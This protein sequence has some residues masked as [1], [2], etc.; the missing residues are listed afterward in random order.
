MVNGSCSQ[1]SGKRPGI[2][3]GPEEEFPLQIDH[4]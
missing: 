2:A 3:E 4:S 1:C